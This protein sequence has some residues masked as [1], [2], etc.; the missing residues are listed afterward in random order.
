MKMLVSMDRT[1]SGP[2]AQMLRTLFPDGYK[3][4]IR[5]AERLTGAQRA[6]TNKGGKEPDE[7]G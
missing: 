3:D 4:M 1:A 7:Q 5:H 2:V 6:E